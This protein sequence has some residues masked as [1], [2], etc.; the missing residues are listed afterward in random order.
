[1]HFILN[2]LENS[3][4]IVEGDYCGILY[5]TDIILLCLISI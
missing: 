2:I 3:R 1:M 4:K 5:N